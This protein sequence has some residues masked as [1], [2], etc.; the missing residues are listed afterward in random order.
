MHLEN[1]KKC[2]KALENPV[3]KIA[4]WFSFSKIFDF[5]FEICCHHCIFLLPAEFPQVQNRKGAAQIDRKWPVQI[6][7]W[8]AKLDV[9]PGYAPW[10]SRQGFQGLGLPKIPRVLRLVDLVAAQKTSDNFRPSEA[11]LKKKLDNVFFGFFSKSMPEAIH[12]QR[13]YQPYF[14]HKQP[15][16]QFCF[17]PSALAT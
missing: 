16:I 5:Q 11:T 1:V 7:E 13:W 8:E 2:E 9:R 12:K 3:G 15:D 17:G 6:A 4:L 10:T 14:G